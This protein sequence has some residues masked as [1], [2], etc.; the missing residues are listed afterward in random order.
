MTAANAM[1]GL[2]ASANQTMRASSIETTAKNQ[3]PFEAI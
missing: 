2:M 3:T 1:S